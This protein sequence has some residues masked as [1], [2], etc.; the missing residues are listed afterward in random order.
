MKNI[1]VVNVN[2]I[3]DVIFSTPVFKA[4]KGYYPSAKVCCMAVPRVVSVL[5]HCP[6]VD[7]IL[8]Y[9]ER[10]GHRWPWGKFQIVRSLRRYRFDAAFLL[11]RSWT[12]AFLVYLAGIRQRI[13][14]DLK[15]LGRLLTHKVELPASDAHRSDYYLHILE[16]YGVRVKDRT[17]ELSCGNE[18]RVQIANFLSLK[19]IEKDDFLVVVNAGGNWD[20]KRWPRDYFAFLIE[21]VMR[22][23][24]AKV[25]IPGAEKDR[26]LAEDIRD[27]S[28]ADPV[29]AVGKTNL[30]QLFA[31]MERADVV[32]SADSGPLHIASSVGTDTVGIFG[33]TRPE[34]TGPRGWGETIVLQKDIRCNHRACYQLDC[35]D[36]R[37]MKAVTAD[38][39][40]EAVGTFYKKWQKNK[41]S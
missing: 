17:T 3:G 28:G 1:L 36:N 39:V 2:W 34:I 35:P 26:Q 7:D 16:S 31:L 23:M 20:L 32:V 9:D 21:R 33:P 10:G 41:N 38:D 13:G 24:K 27:R 5:K 18:E 11:H 37:C 8:V 14:Y 12:R 29:L 22:D 30:E 19:G 15:D 6:Y 4:L 40:V 25:V